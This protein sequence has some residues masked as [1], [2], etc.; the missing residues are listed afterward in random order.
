M[1]RTCP[2]G[3]VDSDFWD[4][5]LGNIFFQH[6]VILCFTSFAI[7]ALDRAGF[8]HA[9]AGYSTREPVS[10]I[11]NAVGISFSLSSL[12][13]GAHLGIRLSARRGQGLYITTLMTINAGPTR[14]ASG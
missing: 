7:I 11:F 2:R 9:A 1:A 10:K 3:I 8:A 14:L 13:P 12:I 6:T 5:C 4:N